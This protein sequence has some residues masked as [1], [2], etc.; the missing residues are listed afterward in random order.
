MPT[1]QRGPADSRPTV[2]TLTTT[3]PGTPGD[4]TPEFVLSLARELGSDFAVTIL[5]PRVPGADRK[6]RLGTVEI[7]R[8]PYFPRPLEGLADGAILPNLRASPWRIVEVAFLVGSMLLHAFVHTVRSRPDLVHAHWIVPG[9]FVAGVLKFLTGRP[10]VLTVHG[11]DVYGI[12]HPLYVWLRDRIVAASDAVL[13]VSEHLAEELRVRERHRRTRVVPMGVDLEGVEEPR[14]DSPSTA[15][16]F[17]FVG[18]LAEKKGVDVLLRACARVPEAR[19]VVIGDGPEEPFL[20]GLANELGLEGRVDFRGRRPRREVLAALRHAS[21]LVIP[22][23]VAGDGDQD[24]T[25]VVL[26]E[27][28]A[29]SV[30][31]IASSIGGIAER[32]EQ[33]V[34]GILVEPDSVDDLVTALRRAIDRPDEMA[35]LGRTARSTLASELDMATTGARY[36]EVIREIVG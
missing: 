5:A 2:L 28:I 35:R 23:R 32:L 11:A 17:L 25:P 33:D 30:P 27:G 29:L 6:E 8:F 16:D 24:G 21:V 20:R 10:F 4:G 3:L 36:R 22:S 19:L 7:R 15:C 18:R 26:A 1:D 12:R 31:I 13:P 34:T 9:G 14:A